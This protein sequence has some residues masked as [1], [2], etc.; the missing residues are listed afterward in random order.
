[1]ASPG[2]KTV[3]RDASQNVRVLGESSGGFVGIISGY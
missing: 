1:M 3:E 2:V